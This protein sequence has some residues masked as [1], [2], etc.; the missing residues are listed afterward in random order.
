MHNILR[1]VISIHEST[2]ENEHDVG[3]QLMTGL[4]E[5]KKKHAGKTSIMGLQA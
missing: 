4:F 5:Y 3:K 2:F 1:E